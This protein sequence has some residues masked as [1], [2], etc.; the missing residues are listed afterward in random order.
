MLSLNFEWLRNQSKPNVQYGNLIAPLNSYVNLNNGLEVSASLK[1]NRSQSFD[2]MDQH[3]L[4]NLQVSAKLK[5]CD[6]LFKIHDQFHV[7]NSRALNT[8]LTADLEAKHGALVSTELYD[9]AW[10]CED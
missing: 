4:L 3:K 9:P 5:T 7:S 8:P 10:N 6:P 2:F 1:E